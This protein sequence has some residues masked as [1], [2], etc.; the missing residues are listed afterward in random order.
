MSTETHQLVV[1]GGGP[2]GYPAAYYAADHGLNVT[3]I[4][5]EKNP[6]GVC[7]Y[8]GC[9]PSKALLH[10]AKLINE[11]REAAHWGVTFGEPKVDIAKLREWKNS[12]VTKLTGGLGQMSKMRKVNHIQGR[13]KFTSN[14]TLEVTKP[15]GSTQTVTFE[16]AIVA[17]GSHPTHVPS[18]NI[19]SKNVFDSTGALE[20]ES[21]PEKF[22]VI[23][24]GYIGLEMGSVYAALGSKVTVVEMTPGL[25]PGA[26][27]DLVVHLQ[28]RLTKLFADIKLKTKVVK[29]EE[30]KDGIHVTFEAEDGKQSTEVFG[31]VLISIGRRPNT[32]DLGLEKTAIQI[33]AKGFIVVDPQRR[34]H[35]SNI[36]AI[37]DIAGEPMLAH[38]ATYEGKIAVESIL[39]KKTVYDP[40][41][42]PAVVFT[43]PEIA[44]AGLTETEAKAKGIPVKVGKFPWAAS[45]R[46]TTLDRSDGLTKIIVHPETEQVLG[47]AVCGPGAGELI[48]EGT[49]AIEMG[50]TVQDL[51]LTIHPHPT[52]SET[53]MESAEAF[54]GHSPHFFQPK[55]G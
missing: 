12:V 8:R 35:E 30:K 5:T 36:W 45:G 23:G 29:V 3:I 46:A 33:D 40:R 44:W 18:L 38:K 51:A 54:F 21:V 1:V 10:V 50:A 49:L 9:I 42:I 43:D 20:L 15:D 24:G 22:L 53:V 41:A 13:A 6:G 28:K 25:L 11:S 47:V 37:G 26:D 7:L 17:A 34:T 2:G 27:R 4:D 48:A 19:A 31:K 55:R 39:G 14:T 16:K 32:K 52:L